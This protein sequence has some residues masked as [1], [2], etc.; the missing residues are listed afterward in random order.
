MKIQNIPNK[1]VKID[2]FKFLILYIKSWRILNPIIDKV[3][4]PFDLT[5]TVKVTIKVEVNIYKWFLIPN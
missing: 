5:N 2:F 1:N 4:I 3:N